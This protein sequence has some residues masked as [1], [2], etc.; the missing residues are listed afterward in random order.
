[1]KQKLVPFVD[2]NGLSHWPIHIDQVSGF[3]HYLKKHNGKKIQFTTRCTKDQ[4]L[5]AKRIVN[6][7]LAK[8]LGGKKTVKQKS[9]IKDEL[10]LW[11]S[12][13]ES[14]ET[15]DDHKRHIKNAAERFIEPFWGDKFPIELMNPELRKEWYDWFSKEFPGQQ[16]EG[17]IKFIRNFSTY[18]TQKI[19]NDAP[20][21]PARPSFTDPNK[22]KVRR[23]RKRK[24]AL[25]FTSDDF[26]KIYLSA[27]SEEHKLVV[28]IMYTMATRITETLSLSFDSEIDLESDPPVYQWSDGQNKADHDGF[29]ALHPSL[30][31]PLKRLRKIRTSEGTSMLFPQKWN[32][33]AALKEQ[34]IDWAAWRKRADIGW[35]WTP[36]TFRHTCL[37]NLFNDERNP[38][39]IICKLYRVSLAV[40]L[41]TYVKPTRSGIEKMMT[42]IEVPL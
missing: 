33:Q 32:N 40:A 9:L 34:Q 10:P 22:K 17:P 7:E 28:L 5:R 42:A 31:E 2:E 19:I 14:E 36:H 35:H 6:E 24:K 3:L 4:L 8:R 30:I 16:M 1:M 18:L 12:M 41:E 27:E 37:S 38:Q 21:L 23:E 13:K 26:K 11:V 20:L 39:A 15:T 29:H 25:I